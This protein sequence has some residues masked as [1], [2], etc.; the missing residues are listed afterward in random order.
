MLLRRY[1]FV[2]EKISVLERSTIRKYATVAGGKK[3]ED[4]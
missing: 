1:V 4:M 2:N 3:I